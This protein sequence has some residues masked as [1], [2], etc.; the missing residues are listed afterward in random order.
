MRAW[1]AKKAI[2]TTAGQTAPVPPDL[3]A[4]IDVLRTNIPADLV[5][6]SACDTAQGRVVEG[7]GLV[8]LMRALTVAGA[9]R[10]RIGN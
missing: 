5:V 1:S 2:E 6:L 4:L 8:G 9:R 3:F 7:E 10:V